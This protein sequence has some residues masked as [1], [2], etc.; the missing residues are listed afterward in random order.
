[1]AN[2]TTTA[3]SNGEAKA[4]R[5]EVPTLDDARTEANAWAAQTKAA[6]PEKDAPID[7]L[8]LCAIAKTNMIMYGPPGTAKSM[9]ARLFGDAIVGRVFDILMTRFTGPAELNGGVDVQALKQGHNRRITKGYLPEADVAF[10]DE[11]YKANSAC[12]NTM[13]TAVNEHKFHDDGELKPIPLRCAILASNEFPEDNDNL[14]AFDDRFPMRFEVK[15]LQNPDNFSALMKG[16]LPR[17]TARLRVSSLDVLN[18]HA[19]L[20]EV[21]DDAVQAM[22]TLRNK[23]A[24]KGIYASDRKF[25]AACSLLRARAALV[26]SPRVTTAHLGVLEHILWLRPDQ[27]AIVRELVREHVASWLRDLRAAADIVD[28]QES[29]MASAI[30]GKGNLSSTMNAIAKVAQKLKE[31]DADVLDNLASVPE[32]TE[33]VARL[34]DRVASVLKRGR[35]ATAKLY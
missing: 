34:R 24:E 4:T 35:E 29:A 12:L 6:V 8:L 18:A 23:L 3:A 31:L 19:G 17:V 20:I 7:G 32:A 25:V 14:G 1:M 13:L 26:G 21:G 30:K 11:G 10:L 27:K 33:D 5:Q 22:W 16:E 28:E 15:P 2:L 9:L